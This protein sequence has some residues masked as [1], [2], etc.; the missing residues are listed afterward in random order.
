MF[1]SIVC[2][3]SFGF[4]FEINSTFLLH[5]YVVILV[6][7]HAKITAYVKQDKHTVEY[8][9]F[10]LDVGCLESLKTVSH[11][12]HSLL[13]FPPW[14]GLADNRLLQCLKGALFSL[15][16]FPCRSS[17]HYSFPGAAG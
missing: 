10:C 13:L 4:G 11:P 8:S 14:R 9:V 2:R 12:L 7:M 17:S 3:C 15:L 5:N 16:A 6:V 1:S